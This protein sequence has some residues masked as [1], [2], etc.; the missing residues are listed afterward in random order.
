MSLCYINVIAAPSQSGTD[1]QVVTSTGTTII[2]FDKYTSEIYYVRES[3]NIVHIDFYNVDCSSYSYTDLLRADAL[4][5]GVSCLS[6]T[7]EVNTYRM[8]VWAET[9]PVRLIIRGRSNK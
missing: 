8:S 6:D 3:T 7:V 5:T 9:L 4:L 2:T 1:E